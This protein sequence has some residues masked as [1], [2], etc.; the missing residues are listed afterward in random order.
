M[1][2]RFL[3]RQLYRNLN[4]DITVNMTRAS[5]QHRYEA[6]NSLE[7]ENAVNYSHFVSLHGHNDEH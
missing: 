7:G 1:G 6:S 5:V 3:G 4:S 2:R